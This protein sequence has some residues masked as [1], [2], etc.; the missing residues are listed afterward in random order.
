VNRSLFDRKTGQVGAAEPLLSFSATPRVPI[1]KR[2]RLRSAT[3]LPLRDFAAF[4]ETTVDASRLCL[5]EFQ[6]PLSHAVLDL[7]RSQS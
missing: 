6:H 7:I 3:D 1:E 5:Q 4:S 2:D